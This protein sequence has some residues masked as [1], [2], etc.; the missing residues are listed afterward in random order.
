MIFEL[1]IILFQ[2]LVAA[3]DTKPYKELLHQVFLHV[4]T[5]SHLNYDRNLL[6]EVVGQIDASY[7]SCTVILFT[8]LL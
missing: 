2:D 1:V 8:V 7:T 4:V 3:T 6:A 5:A